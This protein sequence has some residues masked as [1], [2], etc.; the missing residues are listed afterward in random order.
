[1]PDI[2]SISHEVTARG[3]R[4]AVQTTAAREAVV[5]DGSEI[6][7]SWTFAYTAPRT[8]ANRPVVF[9]FNG[10]P[11]CASMWLHLG[12]LAPWRVDVPSDLN[13]TG[14][15][16]RPL[17]ESADCVL[18]VADL[19]FV[20]PIG[21]GFSPSP[22]AAEHAGA[23]RD[24]A[25]TAAIVDGWLRRNDRLGSPVY[26]VGE[27]Y[28]TIRA[29]LAAT[30]LRE[31]GV[32][33]AGIALLGQCLN[34]Q[35]T[36]Q[37]PGNIAGFVAALPFLAATA[38]YHGR[39]AHSA[40]VLDTVVDRAHAFAVG[41]YAATLTASLDGIPSAGF[42]EQLA[43]FTGLSVD[44][45]RERRARVD[46]EEFRRLLLAD[47]GVV[48]GL[49][50]ARY[51]LPAAPP[52]AVEPPLDA[53][54]VR[55]DPVFTAALHRLFV[56]HLGLSGWDGYRPAVPAH[57]GWDYLEASAVG[58]FG[59]SALPSPFALFDYPAHLAAYLR[60]DPSARVFVGTGQFDALTTVGSARHL[61]TQYGL[62]VQRIVERRYPS[63][64]MMY[65]DAVSRAALAEDLR[66][67]LT[68]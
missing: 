51:R 63:G 47:E 45:L 68:P 8:D 3:G 53:A 13:A 46:K 25:A 56:D 26:L 64:H 54:D 39:G 17:V 1:M 15:P 22:E 65:T 24:A 2:A 35:E 55:L 10:G 6:G 41:E 49:T 44:Q 60:A 28:G 52:G 32:P 38:W 66:A 4:L 37:R 50:D 29:V 33:V 16:R 7:E 48:V 30:A 5:I 42:L 62:P 20:D 9:L 43:G 11:G 61:L 58:R 31:R 57:E 19:V 40:E 18:D 27:S 14:S 36:T 59:G 23:D 34:A 12:G 67:F 21:T